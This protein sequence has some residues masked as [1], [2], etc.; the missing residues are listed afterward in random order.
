V[1]LNL[2]GRGA[3]VALLV[4][5]AVASQLASANFAASP[6]FSGRAGVTCVACHTVAPVG[7]VEAQAVLEGFPESWDPDEVYD[8]TIA[9][10]GGPQAMPAP[11]PQGGF[12]L[13]VGG[14]H[15]LL[16]SGTEDT[17]RLVGTQEATYLPAGTLM[18]QWSVTWVAPDLASYPAAIPVWLAVVSANG[19]HVVATNTSDG[20]ERFDSTA[21]LQLSIPPSTQAIAA[22]RALPLA[23]PQAN[24]TLERDGSWVLDGRHTDANAT[25]LLWSVDGGPWQSRDTAASWKL[26]LGGLD[27]D[28]TVRLRSEGAERS[29]PDVPVTLDS[30]GLLDSV[31][32]G[33]STPLPLAAALIAL[34]FALCLRRC[35][36]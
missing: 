30:P 18:R 24:V 9:V 16:P 17:L 23:A 27:G 4:A 14:G 35:R 36:P 11:Q 33:R 21:A 20:G 31:G 34:A 29:S 2:A 6:G 12:D 8:V 22:W 10:E 1:A 26:E 5:L 19:N 15:L 3:F 25:R 7:Y 32:D 28:H 13:A